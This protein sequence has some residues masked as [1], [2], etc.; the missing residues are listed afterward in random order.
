MYYI[1]EQELKRLFVKKKS[2]NKS[3]K[4]IKN[5]TI[6]FGSQHPTAHGVLRLVLEM[7]GEVVQRSDP[8]IGLLHRGTKKLIEQ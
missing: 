6:N 4:K 2:L 8:H 1:Q 7:N 3:H 5:F